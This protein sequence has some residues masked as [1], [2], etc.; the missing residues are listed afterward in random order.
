M[1]KE[2]TLA[3]H[4]QG[5]KAWNAWADKMRAEREALAEET[6]EWREAARVDFGGHTFKEEVS[7]RD[8]QFP[9]VVNFQRATFR[10]S[11]WFQR[12][13]FRGLAAFDG[14]T[15]R[16]RAD[17]EDATFRDRAD[18][19]DA[20]FRGLASFQRATFRGSASFQRATF[21]D[22]ATFEGVTFRDWVSF[23]GATFRDLALFEGATF[24]DWVAFEGAT[25]RNSSDFY[26][27]T[28]RESV[29][30]EDV[31]FRESAWFG[32][33][34]FR[35]LADFGQFVF[36]GF[37]SFENTRFEAEANFAAIDVTSA[38]TM[39][40]ATFLQLP[41]FNQAHFAEAPRLDALHIG[42]KDFGGR[43][44]DLVGE[45]RREK[46]AWP[47]GAKS[48]AALI[49]GSI[50]A[51]ISRIPG[52]ARALWSGDLIIASRWRALKRLAE[53]GLD[54][55][56]EQEFFR[57]ELLARRWNE[58]KP[59]GGAFWFGLGYQWF[60]GFGVSLFRPLAWW[61][62]GQLAAAWVYLMIYQAQGLGGG[63]SSFGFW[64][65][66]RWLS[67][68]ARGFLPAWLPGGVVNP[69]MPPCVT[70]PGEPVLAALGLAAQKALVVGVGSVD[71]TRQIHA[72]LFGLREGEG[73]VFQAVIPDVVTVL[74]M[75]QFMF[76]AAMVFLFGLALRNHFRIR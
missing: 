72:C 53:Q 18:F 71:K 48:V 49:G 14:A 17:F 13:T 16:D 24:R 19:E 73:P 7:F 58:D 74:S 76:S 11:A 6:E 63:W 57:R 5:R 27:A 45:I 39:V 65:A 3:L 68:W 12:A 8:L 64:N 15:F 61:G 70:G 56:R 37:A 31:T 50:I 59:W 21:R 22:W 23:D 28:F 52:A 46:L 66:G 44:W 20:T 4:A 36:R 10:D 29:W 62:A 47:A 1:N 32:R 30:F 51:P 54:H 26:C 67:H 25:F 55:A 33:T 75:G 38:F 9:D 42:P 40:G 69:S 41:D 2:E 34:T 35:D 43:F 60:S